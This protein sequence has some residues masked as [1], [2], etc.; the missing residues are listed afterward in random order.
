MVKDLSIFLKEKTLIYQHSSREKAPDFERYH[1]TAGAWGEDWTP[2]FLLTM[3]AF[4]HWTTQACY[5]YNIKG[6]EDEHEYT[7][8]PSGAED[9]HEYTLSP[10][11]AED[12]IRTY[13]GF[14][15]QFYRLLR[16]AASVPRHA[17][18]SSSILEPGGRFELPT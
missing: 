14:R 2:D 13:V 1:G 12:R 16:L 8:S 11:G 7:L 10:S 15:Q 9:E 4:Y 6:A 17:I 5:N 3:E 18:Y